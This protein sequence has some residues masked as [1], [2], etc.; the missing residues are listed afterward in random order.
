MTARVPGTPQSRP[1]QVGLWPARR[2][3]QKRLWPQLVELAAIVAF[4]VLAYHGLLWYWTWTAPKEIAIPKVVGMNE[5]EALRVLSAAGLRPEVANRK[6]SEERP[7]GAVLSA[8][9]PPGRQVKVGR[10]VRLIVSSGSRWS[11]VPDVREMSVDRSRALVA[12]QNLEVGKQLARFHQTVPVG[13]VIAQNPEPG[14]KLPR[15]SAID[16][17]VSKGPAPAAEPLEEVR[18]PGVRSTQ[19][20]YLV[21]PGASLKE[22]RI[23][24][25]DRKG[26][27]TIYRNFHRPGETISETVTGE[28]PEAVV[29]VYVSGVVEVEKSF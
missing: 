20:E 13:Y 1:P 22:V 4:L 6:G 18:R 24:V 2:R 8:E 14:K 9:P 23:E 29:R 7:A 19:V 27:R 11:V 15:S 17:V 12:Q 16:L 25:E 26:V 5:Q 21:P 28:G 3:P 10:K